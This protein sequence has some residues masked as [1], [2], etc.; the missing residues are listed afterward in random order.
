MKILMWREMEIKRCD[1]CACRSAFGVRLRTPNA[2]RDELQHAQE[3]H[4]IPFLFRGE[5]GFQDQ[6]EEL[7]GV[8]ES[9]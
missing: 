1:E 6:V 4:Q 8:L 5:A 9:K 2:S 7:D 3:R